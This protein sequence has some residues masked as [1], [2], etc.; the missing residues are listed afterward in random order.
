M[1]EQGTIEAVRK[2]RTLACSPERAFRAFTEEMAAWW[3]LVTHSVG[4]EDA[5]GVTVDGRVGGEITEQL[6]DGSTSVWGTITAW[7]PPRRLAFTWHAGTDPG[8]A[9]AVEVTF[10]PAGDGCR[11]TLVHRGWERRP[12]GVDMRRSYDG[13]WD[14]VLERYASALT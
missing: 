12:D 2:E 14:L 11:L 3:P 6:R 10:E 8:Q 5:V 4:G 7:D 9:T 1:T 13:G